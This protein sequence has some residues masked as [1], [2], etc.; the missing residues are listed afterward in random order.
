MFKSKNNYK[1]FTDFVPYLK[2]IMQKDIMVSVTNQ[3]KFIAYEPGFKLDVGVEV[4]REIPEKDPLRMTIMNNQIMVA[5]VPEEVYGIPFRA[6]TYP[7]RNKKGECIG[8]VGV[9]ESLAKEQE[10]NQSLSDIVQRIENTNNGIQETALD[11]DQIV[12]AIQDYSA[13]TEEVTAS[14]EGLNNLSSDINDKIDQATNISKNVINS[15]EDGIASIN[16]INLTMETFINEISEVK[17]KIQELDDS[18]KN[19][20]SIINL[21]T[22]ISNQTN[23]LALNASIEAARAGEHGKGFAVVADEVG[24]LAIQSQESASEISQIMSQIQ[25]EINRVVEDVNQTVETAV[26]G[27]GEVSTTT[28]NIEEIIKDNDKVYESIIDIKAYTE[29]QVENTKEMQ[30]AISDLATSV[31]ETAMTGVDVNKKIQNQ[32]A[33]VDSLLDE[34]NQTAENLMKK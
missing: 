9:G 4:G 12:N 2:E 27:H 14:I 23:L 8:A 29:N 17:D 33:K 3:N 32:A 34:I 13:T 15:G 1:V 6:V 5:T 11:V 21:I 19:A 24:K 18:I 22:D 20:Y 26:T 31:D 30:R 28:E 25:D 16:K 7:I 10:I